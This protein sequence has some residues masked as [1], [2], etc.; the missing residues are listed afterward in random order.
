MGVL[1][2][3]EPVRRSCAGR[4]GFANKKRYGWLAAQRSELQLQRRAH[5][6]V[7]RRRGEGIAARSFVFPDGSSSDAFATTSSYRT[8][9]TTLQLK[10]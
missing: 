6:P 4:V 3:V 5:G 8:V 9:R 7:R 10:F 2:K 1:W